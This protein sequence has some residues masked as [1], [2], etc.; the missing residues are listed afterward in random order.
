MSRNFSW[1]FLSHQS[2]QVFNGHFLLGT[3]YCLTFLVIK[4]WSYLFLFFIK[5][6]F[7]TRLVRNALVFAFCLATALVLLFFVLLCL[8]Y[9]D[10]FIYSRIAFYIQCD[11]Q[12]LLNL[13][14]LIDHN[15]YPCIFIFY[16]TVRIY[17]E[18]FF[19]MYKN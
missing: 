19:R 5:N 3:L 18:D 2:S 4:P 1:I 17:T 7:S 14:H 15:L 13:G 6:S 10:S 12:I 11:Q 9:I 8:F 16:C